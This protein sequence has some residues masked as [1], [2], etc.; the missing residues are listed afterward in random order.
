MSPI[1][2]N[3]HLDSTYNYLLTLVF[4]SRR[5]KPINVCKIKNREWWGGLT[6]HHTREINMGSTIT[7]SSWNRTNHHTWDINMGSTITNSSCNRTNHHTWDINMGSTITNS[8]WN[9]TNHHTWDINMGS[10]ITNSSCNRNK[11]E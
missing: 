2:D 10:T 8:S 3:A 7:N 4:N 5:P 6:N 1:L 9:R 11:T